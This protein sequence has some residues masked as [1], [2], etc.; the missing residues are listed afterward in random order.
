MHPTRRIAIEELTQV[1]EARRAATEL[2]GAIGLPANEI[3]R[4]AL[5]TTEAASN[6]LKHAGRGELLMCAHAGAAPLLEILVIDAGPGFDAESAGVDGYSTTGTLGGGLGALRRLSSE[7][8]IYSPPGRGS[9]LRCAIHAGAAPTPRATFDV[10]AISLPHPGETVC[11]DAFGY[12]FDGQQAV[13]VVADGLG[14]GIL[15]RRAS[16]RVVENL[17]PA[18]E[19]PERLLGHAHVALHATRGAAVG[20]SVIDL[21]ARQLRFAGIGNIATLVVTPSA[22]KNLVSL[23]GIVGHNVRKLQA[24]EHPFGEHSLLIMHSDGLGTHWQLDAY[25]GLQAQHPAIVAAVLY[26]DHSRGRDDVAVLV[27]R[28]ARV[29]H[30]MGNA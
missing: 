26:R 2:A 15:A 10:G 20:V 16:E 6:V 23:A 30:A 24:F 9:V 4:A 5:V 27:A 14:H 19:P 7:M 28:A 18:S 13:F 25:P 17:P 11:G 8:Q 29:V 22:S 1:A 3:E 12:R 21:A